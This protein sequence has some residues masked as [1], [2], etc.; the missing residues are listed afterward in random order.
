MAVN[1]LAH[2]APK[3]L[4][5][6]HLLE[7]TGP[8]L[9]GTHAAGL[10]P[11]RPVT[12]GGGLSM[13]NGVLTRDSWLSVDGFDSDAIQ[14]AVDA[15]AASSTRFIYFPPPPSS[16]LFTGA[17]DL[18]GVSNI[19]F[20]GLSNVEFQTGNSVKLERGGSMTGPFFTCDTSNAARG[21]GYSFRNLHFDG[22]QQNVDAFYIHGDSGSNLQAR[23][24]EFTGCTFESLRTGVWLGDFTNETP[25]LTYLLGVDLYRC[26]FSDCVRPIVADAGGFDG[27]NLRNVWMVDLAD[28]MDIGVSILTSGCTVSMENVWIGCGDS[29]THAIYSALPNA[30]TIR[31]CGIEA[32]DGGETFKGI[33]IGAGPSPNG[34]LVL[35]N[36]RINHTS[37]SAVAV[38]VANTT[39]VVIRNSYF[40]GDVNVGTTVP[41]H[42]DNVR[43][44]GSFGFTGTPANVFVD[45]EASWTWTPSITFNTPGD[46]SVAYSTRLGS[47][48][49]IGKMVTAHFEIVTSTFTHTTASGGLVLS[50]L[51]YTSV[52]TYAPSIALGVYSGI[53]AASGT[54]EVTGVIVPNS[55]T[56]IFYRCGSGIAN[57]QLDAGDMPTGGTVK[58]SGSVTYRATT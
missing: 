22:N 50:G 9:A 21:G 27:L 53:T 45:G 44:S 4:H 30:I 2:E 34:G 6:R 12:L 54:T 47:Y 56:C 20:I 7:G 33:V 51:P 10:Q 8:V 46:L 13:V 26:F 37:A 28:R 5:E 25:N 43:F 14:A 41:V 58:L 52:A 36:V 38:E 42:A 1:H 17:V 39:D 57:V 49:K 55:S 18:S 19:E 24:I 35:D 3:P 48:S 31:D 16:Y 11:V 29:A 40:M 23:F 32:N 15:A